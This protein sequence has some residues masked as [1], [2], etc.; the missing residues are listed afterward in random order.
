MIINRYEPT[1]ASCIAT[2]NIM[3]PQTKP[4]NLGKTVTARGW[5]VSRDD[6][7]TL[8]PVGAVG[9]LLLEGGA[10]GVGYLNNPEKTAQAFIND[11]RWS[12]EMFHDDALAS[13]RIY[14]TGDLVKYNEDGTMLVSYCYVTRWLA[15]V[16]TLL[17]SWP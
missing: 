8:A 6:H 3:T 10:V 11:V 13:L 12:A 5:I 1:E 9:E 16:L 4:N 17:V 15:H 14:K 7:H 2:S